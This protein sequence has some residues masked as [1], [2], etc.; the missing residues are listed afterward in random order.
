M[1][2]KAWWQAV[3]AAR[4]RRYYASFTL[5]EAEGANCQGLML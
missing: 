4:L 5:Q 1:V 3:G 2:K